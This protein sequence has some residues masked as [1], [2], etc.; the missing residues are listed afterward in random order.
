MPDGLFFNIPENGTLPQIR[1]FEDIINATQDKLDVYIAVPFE[2]VTGNNCQLEETNDN[3][4]TRYSLQQVEVLDDNL[5]SNLRAVGLARQ[6]FYI[7]F[8]NEVLEEFSVLKIGEIIRS[9]DN[10][11]MMNKDFIP[12]IIRLSSSD[13]LMNYIRE[14]L[15][16]LVS[17]SKELSRQMNSNKREISIT[18]VEILLLLQTLNTYIPLINQ[19]YSSSHYHPELLYSLLLSLCGQLTSLMSSSGIK[20]VD[21]RPYDHNNLNEVFHHLYNQLMI[22][23]NIQKKITK[24]DISI[25]L[26]KQS[27]SLFIGSLKA[28]HLDSLL[29]LVV[30]G[31]LPE[32]K[33]ISE[34][35]NN[36]KIAAH[37]EIFAVHQAGLQGVSIEYIS[38]PPTGL[39]VDP[40]NHYF[41]INKEG[42]F[43]DKIIEKQSIAIFLASEFISVK[44]S[45]ISFIP[46]N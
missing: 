4:L 41:R 19:H 13:T 26:E 34:L 43:W 12:T 18:D 46:G 24:P 14:V 8:E 21:L 36:I 38:R 11:F 23:L 33:I 6:N 29:F 2:H 16:G 7:K 17:K 3:K 42:R 20:P 30:Q 31:D 1:Q 10:T 45:L 15:S 27:E 32:S 25:P 5:G 39:S 40:E 22:L 44:P 37:E 35:P 9:S 28:E